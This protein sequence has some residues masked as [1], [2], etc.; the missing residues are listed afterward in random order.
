MKMAVLIFPQVFT[1]RQ[2]SQV[3]SLFK[4][5]FRWKA[6]RSCTGIHFISYSWKMWGKCGFFLPTRGKV[7]AIKSM[8]NVIRE[9]GWLFD[10]VVSFTR[11]TLN[12]I[13]L[14]NYQQRNENYTGFT[15]GLFNNLHQFPQF[16]TNIIIQQKQSSQSIAKPTTI[17]EHVCL[18][19][20]KLVVTQVYPS[21]LDYS[22]LL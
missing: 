13:R 14:T 3:P 4:V 12:G 20:P 17:D 18:F 9:K 21:Y 15:Q 11:T 7:V 19:N 2:A 10:S 16:S 1:L 22:K 6:V 8:Y 5:F